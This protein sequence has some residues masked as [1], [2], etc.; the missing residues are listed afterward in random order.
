MQVSTPTV[1][2]ED[3]N[4]LVRIVKGVELTLV[5]LAGHADQKF[6]ENDAC[7]LA[8]KHR[9]AIELRDRGSVDLVGV[10]LA[11][12]LQGV[13]AEHLQRIA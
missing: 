3:S 12:E 1:L 2:R 9:A 6:G 13:V 5:V 8:R 7:F 4:A 10:E 11:A